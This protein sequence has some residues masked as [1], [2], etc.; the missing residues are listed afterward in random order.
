MEGEKNKPPGVFS[1]LTERNGQ[2][3]R[4]EKCESFIDGTPEAEER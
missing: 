1:S 2:V 4:S 3:L